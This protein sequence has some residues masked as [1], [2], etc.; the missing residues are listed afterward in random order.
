MDDGAPNR[1]RLESLFATA[2]AGDAQ[3]AF[4]ML[5]DMCAPDLVVHE[6]PFVPWGGDY[7]GREAFLELFAHIAQFTDPSSME[8]VEMVAEGDRVI[9][10]MSGSFRS[11]DGQTAPVLLSEWYSFRDGRVVEIRPFY[12]DVPPTGPARPGEAS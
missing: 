8:V 3:Q 7:H 9:V 6:P 12:W 11:A 10:L 1:Q 4:G 5:V 2:R